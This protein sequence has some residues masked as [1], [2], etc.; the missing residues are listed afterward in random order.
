MKRRLEATLWMGA[1]GVAAGVLWYGAWIA[2]PYL[3]SLG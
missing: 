3:R 2:G 1:Y